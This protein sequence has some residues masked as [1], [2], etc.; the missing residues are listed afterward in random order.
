M[1]FPGGSV[2]QNSPANA[3][4]KGLVPRSVTAPGRGNGIPLQYAYLKS[5]WREE[6]GWLQSMGSQRV[7]HD[8]VTEHADGCYSECHRITHLSEENICN[9]LS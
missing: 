2:L 4:N 8:L 6:P 9:A 7:G 3:G 1:G 5:P